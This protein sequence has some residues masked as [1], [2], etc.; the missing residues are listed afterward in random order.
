MLTQQA[1]SQGNS[2]A[3]AYTASIPINRNTKC[4]VWKLLKFSLW[5]I[6]SGLSIGSTR[7]PRLRILSYM[8]V[9]IDTSYNLLT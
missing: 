8:P 7:M 4:I 6:L 5:P 1:Y 2:P 9:P 3:K